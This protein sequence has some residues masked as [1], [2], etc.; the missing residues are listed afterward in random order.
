MAP[1]LLQDPYHEGAAALQVL[2]VVVVSVQR[3]RNE[4]RSVGQLVELAPVYEGEPYGQDALG[5]EVVRGVEE[6]VELDPVDHA[7]TTVERLEARDDEETTVGGGEA[8]VQPEGTI[9][10][11]G[12]DGRVVQ[13]ADEAPPVF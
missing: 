9:G 5:A 6:L 11:P 1:C 8:A 7:G 2:A 4:P 3:H 13:W 10:R 12:S